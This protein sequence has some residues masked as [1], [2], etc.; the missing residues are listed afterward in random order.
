MRTLSDN[1]P[2]LQRRLE[3]VDGHD[4]HPPPSRRQRRCQRLYRDW[5]VI[6]LEVGEDTSVGGGVSEPA[7]GALGEGGEDA[8]VEAGDA[9]L[10]VQ[11]PWEGE[12]S[13][14]CTVCR[15]LMV[16]GGQ[17]NLNCMSRNNMVHG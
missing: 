10:L 1:P 13:F 17:K 16:I 9:A 6:V 7:D 3:R 2:Y 15:G 12:K 8:A 14:N 5:Q 4:A 11:R